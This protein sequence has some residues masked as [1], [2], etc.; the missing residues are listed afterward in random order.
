MTTRS[1]H[2]KPT[3]CRTA[4]ALLALC[5][6]AASVQAGDIIN[7]GDPGE[8]ER[9]QNRVQL[10][11]SIDIGSDTEMSDILFQGDGDETLDPGDVYLRSAFLL[12]GLPTDGFRDDF[13]A[14]GGIDPG[15]TPA[16]GFGT[17]APVCSGFPVGQNRFEYFDLDGHD[18]IDFQLEQFIPINPDGE[19]FPLSFPI[20]F[21]DSACVFPARFLLLSFDDDDREDY[22]LCDVPTTTPSIAGATYGTTAA[23]DE[24]V[25]IDTAGPFW[26]VPWFDYR[27]IASER[28]VN[29]VLA[30]DPVNEEDDDDVDSLDV[31]GPLDQSP[32][33]G[34]CPFWYFTP[35]HEAHYFAST[36]AGVPFMELDPGGI[37]SGTSGVPIKVIDETVH[38]GISPEAD[39]DAFEFVWAE[40]NDPQFPDAPAGMLVFA[41]LYSVDVDDP[42]TPGDESGGLDPAQVYI[43]YLMGSSFPYLEQPL[44]DDIDAIANHCERLDEPTP[45]CGTCPG[46]A[47][48]D[49]VVTTADITFVVSNLGASGAAG[50][51]GDANCD[52]L[53]STADIT[54]VVSNLGL[55]CP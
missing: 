11:W 29:G 38:L 35:D 1:T 9:D 19:P 10:E 53:V 16:G 48:G 41:I 4:I 28:E 50:V 6:L 7:P 20:E 36:P 49:G 46:D 15:P 21:F 33:S 8:C 32:T 18:S 47:N 26:P 30:P 39:V 27:G 37:Y 24:V 17:A 43:S 13:V 54:L 51:P 34:P 5:G 14:F 2:E 45:P 55:V 22:S 3:T 42:N 12:P 31:G 44:F 52:G 23:R 40:F 25:A